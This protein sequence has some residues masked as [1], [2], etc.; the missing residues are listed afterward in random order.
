MNITAKCPN[1][2]T[3]IF[4]SRF[5]DS[6]SLCHQ[7][8]EPVFVQAYAKTQNPSEAQVVFRCTSYNCQSYFVAYY[9][10]SGNVFNIDKTRPINLTALSFEEELKTLSPSFCEIYE[11]AYFAE[12]REYKEVA[13]CGYRKSLEFLVKDYAISK[14]SAET[15]E[16]K[17]QMLSPVINKYIDDADIKACAEKATWL[18]NDET[19]YVRK[20]GDMDI[21]DLKELIDLTRYWIVKKI[22]TENYLKK[23]AKQ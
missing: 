1:G 10:K 16:I 17:K 2:Q 3:N 22:K 13:G 23:M 20:W 8:Q 12:Q 6:C 14:Y 21:K 19:H 11:Q 15:D 18:G 5:P 9:Q 7:S 4:L